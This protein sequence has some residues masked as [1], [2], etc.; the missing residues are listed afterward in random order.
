MKMLEDDLVYCS[1]S[2]VMQ[3][4]PTSKPRLESEVVF[5]KWAWACVYLGAANGPRYIQ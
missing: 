2:S 3:I 5:M 4:I 1:L